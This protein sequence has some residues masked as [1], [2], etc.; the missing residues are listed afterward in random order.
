[1]LIQERTGRTWVGWSKKGQEGKGC[2]NPGKNRKDKDG[3]VQNRTGRTRMGHEDERY[4][5]PRKGQEV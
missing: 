4:Y 5:Y 3:I 1:M 2:V